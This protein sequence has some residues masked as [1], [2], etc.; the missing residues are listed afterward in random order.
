M[1]SDSRATGQSRGDG[2]AAAELTREA[3]L[4]LLADDYGRGFDR[5]GGAQEERMATGA[6][7]GGVDVLR[8]PS[9][10]GGVAASGETRRLGLAPHV[11]ER[12]RRRPDGAALHAR[13]TR[14]MLRRQ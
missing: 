3:L 2:G 5:R 9:P 1:L 12:D 4:A 6:A 10:R 7:L 11:V 8:V 14:I 13:A